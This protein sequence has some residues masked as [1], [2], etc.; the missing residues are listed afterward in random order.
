MLNLKHGKKDK[1]RTLRLIHLSERCIDEHL[2]SGAITQETAWDR[3]FCIL[4]LCALY[5]FLDDAERIGRKIDTKKYN[6]LLSKDPDVT[7]VTHRTMG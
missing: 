6:P 7:L 1:K 5:S 4:H 3:Y 2:A